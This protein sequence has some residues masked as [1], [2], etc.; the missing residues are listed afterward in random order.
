MSKLSVV[1]NDEVRAGCH[2]D[3]LL[4]QRVFLLAHLYDVLLLQLLHGKRSTQIRLQLYLIV[5][6]KRLLTSSGVNV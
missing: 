5:M 4:I 3:V 6:T 1:P 2:H